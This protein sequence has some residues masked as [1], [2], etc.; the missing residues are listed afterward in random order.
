VDL[1]FLG[2]RLC[3]MVTQAHSENDVLRLVGV[4]IGGGLANHADHSRPEEKKNKQTKSAKS[5]E[6]ST[7]RV[8][9]PKRRLASS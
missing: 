3:V 7:T 6:A 8:R 2:L 1:Y 5:D 4:E 9:V